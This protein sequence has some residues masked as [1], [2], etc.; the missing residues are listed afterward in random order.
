MGVS[1]NP[2]LT[3]SQ[4]KSFTF[5]T[6]IPFPF[7]FY[8][9]IFYFVIFYFILFVPLVSYRFCLFFFREQKS[10]YSRKK[11]FISPDPFVS[12]PS[13]SIARIDNIKVVHAALVCIVC[14]IVKETEQPA[15]LSFNVQINK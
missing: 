14:R 5:T 12:S 1:K 6:G 15:F 9:I 10:C 13:N 2:S 7:Y 4:F 3:S 8:F 11:N